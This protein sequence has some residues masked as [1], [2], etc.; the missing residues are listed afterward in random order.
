MGVVGRL[1]QY[2]SM[3]AYEFDETTANTP[4]ITGFGTYYASEFNENIVDIVGDGLVLNLDAGNRSSYSGSGTTWTD[5]SGNGSNAT[6]VNSPTYSSL[7]SGSLVFNGVND[8]ATLSASSNYSFGTGNFTIE[9]WFNISGN[10]SPDGGGNRICTLFNCGSITSVTVIYAQFYING[11]PTTTGTGIGL[12]RNQPSAVTQSQTISISQNVWHHVVVSKIGTNLNFYLDNSQVG[13]TITDSNSWG[14]NNASHIATLNNTGE[15][16]NNFQGN[17]SGVRIYKGKGLT[18]AEVSQNYNA[19]AGRYGLS[20]PI[21]L[22]ANVFPPYDPVYDEFGGTLFGAGQGRYMRQNTDKS[23]IVYNEIDEITDFRDIVRNG[24]VLDLDAGMNS[25][26]NNI[27]TTWYDLTNSSS[28]AV[29]VGQSAYTTA[30]TFTFTVPAGVTSISAVVIGGGGG[31]AGADNAQIRNETNGGGGGG[32]LA[33]GTISVTPGETLNITVGTGGNGGAA[34]GNGGAGGT[35]TIVRSA[36]TLLSGGGGTGGTYRNNGNSTGGASGG[37]ARIGG[38]SGGAGGAQSNNSGATGGGG[39]GGYSGNGGAGGAFNSAGSAS[40]G[41][42]GGGGGG[43]NTTSNTLRAGGGGGTGILGSGADGTAGTGG[44]GGGGGG[45]SSGTSGGGNTTGLGG[46]Y[47]GG[48]GGKADSTAGTLTIGG[49]GTNGAV[50]IIWGTGRSYPS[51]TVTDQTTVVGFATTSNNAQLINAPT[52]SS[53]NGGY[54]VFNGTNQYVTSSFTTTSGQAVTYSGWLYSTETT[55]TYRNFV[56]SLSATPMIWWNTSGQIEFDAALYTT[57]AV[58]RNQWV[59]VALSKP[60]GNSSPSYYVN[61][62]LVGS[63]S[64]YTT[65]AVT[66]TWFNRA[67]AQTWKGNASN[68]QAYNRELSAA[69]ILQNYNALKHRFGL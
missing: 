6:L 40:T 61:G 50:R 62:V 3:L 11:D 7:N 52:Y 56:D 21:P 46:Q 67:A 66:P 64:A 57:T 63:G 27:G 51:T 9:C 53:A 15:F 45:G 58:Y 39:A 23:V 35:S 48:G 25:S 68:V 12:Y 59:Y 44:S 42:G 28:S 26:F 38:G 13:S 69:E 33:Y 14:S 20:T 16:Q 54:L 8:Y 49:A 31:G 24:M 4:S 30:G 17:I 36:T 43:Y 32:G 18:A 10:S 55:A 19:L 60:S 65:P 34:D 5:L 29:S 37:T 22:T 2:A 1:D 41:A 47:G